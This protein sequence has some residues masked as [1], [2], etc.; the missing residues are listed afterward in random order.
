MRSLAMTS[1]RETD[2][3]ARALAVRELVE[4]QRQVAHARH[5][6]N[7]LQAQL[8]EAQG[9][10][11]SS[12]AMQLREANEHLVQAAVLAHSDAD[13]VRQ[14]LEHASRAAEVD[15]LTQL[16]NRPV[17]FSRFTQAIATAQRVGHRVAILFVDLDHFKQ[18]NDTLGHRV[19]DEVLQ[20]AA[21]C[22]CSVVRDADTV[23]RHGG[24]EFLIL[25]PDLREGSAASVVAQKVITAL[26]QPQRLG[27][28]VFQLTASI[29]VSI[30]PDD[31]IDPDTL[32]HLADLAMYQAKKGG[33]GGVACHGRDAVS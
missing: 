4:L 9:S 7:D 25:L 26:A 31:G 18:I 13:T 28:R 8:G 16:P 30:F 24:D 17:L 29:G 32:I 14:A 5:V 2:L 19:G 15:P 11:D 1:K 10:L 3:D 21:R 12:Q 20:L 23:S 22:L 33:H 27:E 6:L